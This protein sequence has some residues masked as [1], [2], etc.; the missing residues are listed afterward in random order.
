MFKHLLV[1]LDGSSLAEAA[2]PAAVYLAQTLD[3]SV[4]LMHIIETDAPEKVHGE[5]HLADPD[6]ARHYLDEVA[7][8]AFPSSLRVERHV[9]TRAASDVARA[10]F[11]HVDELAPDLIVMCTHGRGGLRGLLFGSIAQQVIA[12]GQT[13]VLL[14]RPR[15]E[16]TTE[17]GG[18]QTEGIASPPS[19]RQGVAPTFLLRRVLVPLDGNPDHEQGLDVAAGLAR[20]CSADVY[21]L[22]VIP[23]TDTLTWHS[24]ATARLLPSTTAALL[25]IAQDDA[26]S[27]LRKCM[28]PLQATGL[29]VAAEIQRGEPAK[30]IVDTARRV[31]ADLI[32]LGTHGRSGMD[33][34]WSGSITPKVA[35]QTGLPL[36]LVP[37]PESEPER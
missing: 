34:F 26:V 15:E 22:M 16:G 3:A 11:E 8:R 27:Y 9:H 17:T 29:G 13:P 23:T 4:T 12:L 10:I 36:L 6:E 21:M 5:Q 24:G 28:A 25:D 33:A 7:T 30:T 20:A 37:V 1:P 32:A 19:G 31:E 35:G 14:I 2:L 18:E